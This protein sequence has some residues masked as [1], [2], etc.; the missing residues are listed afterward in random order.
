MSTRA[1]RQGTCPAARRESHSIE[2]T[3]GIHSTDPVTRA[4]TD[5]SNTAPRLA[6]PRASGVAA[7]SS[8]STQRYAARGAAQ[9]MNAANAIQRI[10]AGAQTKAPP[11]G[12]TNPGRQ[13]RGEPIEQP[14]RGGPRQHAHQRESPGPG[15]P[16]VVHLAHRAHQR[17]AANGCA[18]N[19]QQTDDG[20]Q[21]HDQRAT[22]DRRLA[23]TPR[24]RAPTPRRQGRGPASA[25]RHPLPDSRQPPSRRADRNRSLVVLSAA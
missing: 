24:P 4:R 25:T 19:N 17:D 2:A 16:R 10:R 14:R 3:S 11:R 5:A 6:P 22:A 7:A 13:M 23:S 18:R 1:R 12:N 20:P 8:G 9:P 21:R 15:V